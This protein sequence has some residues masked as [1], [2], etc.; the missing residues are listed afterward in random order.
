MDTKNKTNR[1]L[2][3]TSEIASLLEMVKP[4]YPTGYIFLSSRGEPYCQPPKAFRKTTEILCLNENRGK[5]ERITFHSIRH[6]VA[7]KLAETLDIRSLM[8]FMGWKRIEIAARYI[9][10]NEDKIKKAAEK[11]GELFIF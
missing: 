6:S 7:T 10:G 4:E 1:K 2:A 9:H 5:L 8:D 3:L 11:L